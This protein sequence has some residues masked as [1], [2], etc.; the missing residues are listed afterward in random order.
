M[1]LA[2]GIILA[3]CALGAGVCMGI[4]AIGPGVG[5]GGAVAS[6]F[7]VYG[8]E[9]AVVVECGADAA[10]SIYTVTGKLVQQATVEPG[11]N[12][13]PLPGGVYIVNGNKVIVK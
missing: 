11:K 13:I 7:R 9:G 12:I 4:G 1:E 5:E 2:I 3:A 10:V 6:A 8:T